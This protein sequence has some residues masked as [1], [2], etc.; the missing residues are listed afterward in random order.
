M[1]QLKRHKTIWLA[2]VVLLTAAATLA[3][4]QISPAIADYEDEEGP[5]IQVT[6]SQFQFSPDVITLKKGVPVKLEIRTSDVLHGFNCP[7]MGIRAEVRPG[8]VTKISFTP[9]RA[10]EFEFYCDIFC[11]EGHARMTGRFIVEEEDTLP[12]LE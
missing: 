12:P 1:E 11:G 8:E 9:A 4:G 6:A 7:E 10:G 3:L 5:V 2:V